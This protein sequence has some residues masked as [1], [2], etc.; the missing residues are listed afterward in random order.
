MVTDLIVFCLV[1]ITSFFI[2]LVLPNILSIWQGGCS[3]F[4]QYL[5]W[6][7]GAK[8]TPPITIQ[9][10]FKPEYLPLVADHAL[11]SLLASTDSSTGLQIQ[12][13]LAYGAEKKKK[14]FDLDVNGKT[15][16]IDLEQIIEEKM[17]F[18]VPENDYNLVVVQRGINFASKEFQTKYKSTATISLSGL[19]KSMVV[20]YLG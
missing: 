1:V 19:G 14:S 15:V 12:E 10:I 8:C 7:T 2:L 3:I 18:L 4:D 11:Y 16:K 17:K 6:T 13:L 5:G 9:V 20:L